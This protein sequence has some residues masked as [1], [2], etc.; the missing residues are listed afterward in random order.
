MTK[1]GLFGRV[2]LRGVRGNPMSPVVKGPSYTHASIDWCVCMMFTDP[3]F[4]CRLQFFCVPVCLFFPSSIPP[5][6]LFFFVPLSRCVFFLSLSLSTP[7]VH[8]RPSKFLLLFTLMLFIYPISSSPLY[9]E[10]AVS[11][12]FNISLTLLSDAV[13]SL[14]MVHSV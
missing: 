4:V 11:H 9:R 1:Y 10:C 12:L 8:P 3:T 2:S 7:C 13:D 5:L 6:A 14:F